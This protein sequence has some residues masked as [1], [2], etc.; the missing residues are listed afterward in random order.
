V[1]AGL[2][3]AGRQLISRIFELDRKAA[4]ELAD[5]L[6]R[7]YSTYVNPAPP[8]GVP[9]Y[10]YLVAVTGERF[11]REAGVAYASPTPVGPAA[12]AQ[13]GHG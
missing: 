5:E 13:P 9:A 10:E 7:Q 6:A 11:R 4:G 2:I 12:W 1:P 3:V 8:P